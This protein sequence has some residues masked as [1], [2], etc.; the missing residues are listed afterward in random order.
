MRY[1]LIIVFFIFTSLPKSFSQSSGSFSK[2]I[3]FAFYLT[4]NKEYND[5]IFFLNSINDTLKTTAQQDSLNYYLGMNYYLKKSLDTSIIFFS[6]VSEESL[7]SLR[8]RFFRIFNLTYTGKYNDAL[9]ILETVPEENDSLI[10]EY[11]KFQL[12]ALYL[13]ER[14]YKNFDT[15]LKHFNYQ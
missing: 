15:I 2:D 13:L 4:K 12:A 6:K 3:D 1:I 7:L 10:A 11:K 14:N 9:T 5:A 8:S